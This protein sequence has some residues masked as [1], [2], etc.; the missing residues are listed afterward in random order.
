MLTPERVHETNSLGSYTS[1]NSIIEKQLLNSVGLFKFFCV[2]SH[3]NLCFRF[4]LFLKFNAMI[5]LL[6]SLVSYLVKYHPPPWHNGKKD[7]YF[8]DIRSMPF[9]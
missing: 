6:L 9:T 3:I 4:V 2:V 8:K 1:P 7:C 5:L